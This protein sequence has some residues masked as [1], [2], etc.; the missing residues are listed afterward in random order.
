MFK[1]GLNIYRL[2]LLN[3]RR[4]SWVQRP[5]TGPRGRSEALEAEEQNEGGGK[6]TERKREKKAQRR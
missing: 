3:H 4:W 5:W 1:V 2:N 6:K